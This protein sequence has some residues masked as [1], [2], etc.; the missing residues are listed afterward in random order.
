MKHSFIYKE[1]KLALIALSLAL[2]TLSSCNK[3]KVSSDQQDTICVE[4]STSDTSGV[5]GTKT[6]L[7]SP[8]QSTGQSSESTTS[9]SSSEAS[10]SLG[11][12]AYEAGYSSGKYAAGIFEL[13][14]YTDNNDAE[15]KDDY[16][17]DCQHQRFHLKKEYANNRSLYKE[18][19]RGF[20]KAYQD[21][22]DA[23]SAL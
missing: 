3:H 2:C 12:I 14:Y 15:L 10:G 6:E 17:E 18:Y 7:A 21:K 13:N 16:V 9:S 22:E 11:A 4:S 5:E 20:L 8:S 1:Q 19:R 23:K